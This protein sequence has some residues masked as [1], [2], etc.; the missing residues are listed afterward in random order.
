M[1]GNMYILINL[2][3]MSFDN[4]S[5][6]LVQCFHVVFLASKY[7]SFYNHQYWPGSRAE[8]PILSSAPRGGGGRGPPLC[9]GIQEV[10]TYI[11]S[12]TYTAQGALGR[13]L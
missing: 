10:G 2:I 7:T 11:Y 8:R 1:I 12:C 4:T 6:L 13:L 5:Q 9:I 3:Q